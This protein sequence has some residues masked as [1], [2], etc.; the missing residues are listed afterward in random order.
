MSKQLE[1]YAKN[2]NILVVDDDKML[3]KIIHDNLK[4]YFHNIVIANDGQKAFE[5][6]KKAPKDFF[7]IVL[8][9]IK[10]PNLDGIELSKYI[11]N[12]NS[13]QS[14]IILSSVE[15]INYLIDLIE[16]GVDSFIPKPFKKDNLYSKVIKS[17]EHQCFIKEMKLFER[18][19]VLNE[20]RIQ[21][22]LAV[23]Q[24]N[25]IIENIQ[26][27]NEQILQAK[28]E[29]EEQK[30]QQVSDKVSAKV[31]I[32]GI[33]DK[34]MLRY[35]IK[36]L[37]SYIDDLEDT[38]NDIFSQHVSSEHIYN[39][40]KVFNNIYNS[41]ANID[42]NDRLVTLTNVLSDNAEYFKNLSYIEIPQEKQQE[43]EMLEFLL[44]DLKNFLKEVLIEQSSLDI[45]LYA[46]CIHSNFEQLRFNLD[47]TDKPQD[48]MTL[49]F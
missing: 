42:I 41:I 44:D 18:E 12:T 28:K 49:F 10:M 47:N 2:K 21:N 43:L 33:N 16:I 17:L 6:Y 20:F 7:S 24:K 9:D 37:V 39:I 34:E 19:S 32:D 27:R 26:K 25:P 3:C 40:S 30:L 29:E 5:I 45:D 11:K 35:E 31:F 14:I 48:T 38:I 15:D 46:N 23:K 13:S 8:T 22:G 36:H 4:S 1:L